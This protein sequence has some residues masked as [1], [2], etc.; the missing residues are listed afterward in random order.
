MD[1]VAR[2]LVTQGQQFGTPEKRARTSSLPRASDVRFGSDASR[3]TLFLT[4][5]IRHA[6]SM[7]STYVVGLVAI[8]FGPETRGMPSE[9]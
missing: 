4:R 1:D 3:C 8:W 2:L 9:D 7:A 6:I 5:N